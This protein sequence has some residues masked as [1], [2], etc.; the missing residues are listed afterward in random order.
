MLAFDSQ[1]NVAFAGIQ[2][3]SVTWHLK[4]LQIREIVTFHPQIVQRYC[5][6]LKTVLFE[7]YSSWNAY[8][9]AALCC[10]EVLSA[11]QTSDD[12]AG[13]GRW[14]QLMIMIF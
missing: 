4:M 10:P 1:A 7:L 11:Y 5:E 9:W 8:F 2:A 6:L 12:I 3:C 14:D 13:I